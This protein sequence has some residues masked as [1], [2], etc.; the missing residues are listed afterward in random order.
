MVLNSVD[1]KLLN[2]GVKLKAKKCQIPMNYSNATIECP[3]DYNVL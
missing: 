1:R 2:I 3:A